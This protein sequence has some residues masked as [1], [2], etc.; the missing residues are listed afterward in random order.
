MV[1]LSLLVKK[2]NNA[3]GNDLQRSAVLM[4]GVGGSVQKV[5]YP[6]T[7]AAVM[8]SRGGVVVSDAEEIVNHKDAISSNSARSPKGV[9]KL[10]S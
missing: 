4:R 8:A 2:K 3:K 1:L 5:R 10:Q 6:S 9:P 7:L